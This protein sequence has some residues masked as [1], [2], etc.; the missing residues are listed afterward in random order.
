[1]LKHSPII[2]VHLLLIQACGSSSNSDKT[3]EPAEYQFNL[4]AK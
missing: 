2:L 1:M 4:S 3:P